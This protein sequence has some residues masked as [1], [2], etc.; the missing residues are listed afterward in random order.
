M[1]IAR[2]ESS[3]ARCIDRICRVNSVFARMLRGGSGTRRDT[4]L[5]TLSNG[6]EASVLAGVFSYAAPLIP[7]SGAE[8]FKT[9]EWKLQESRLGAISEN[10]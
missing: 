10:R 8:L 6:P 5:R 9:R 2:W 4:L 3:N 7:Q 1:W